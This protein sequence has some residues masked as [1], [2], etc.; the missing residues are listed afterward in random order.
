LSL[1]DN[2]P[3]FRLSRVHWYNGQALLP[4]HFNAQEESL[5]G[6]V[7]VRLNLAPVP[8]WGLGAL[9]FNKDWTTSGIISIERMVLV[10]R[11]GVVLD[12]PGNT[13]P[14]SF[15]LPDA[16]KV[17]LY[18]HL[19]G[20]SRIETQKGSPDE[21]GI[22]RV[23]HKI[24]LSSEEI[25]PSD[26]PGPAFKI[27]E[28]G[29]DPEGN[30][31]VN[32][33]YLPPLICVGRSKPLFDLQLGRMSNAARDLREVLLEDV[34][35]QYLDGESLAAAKVALRAVFTF[36]HLLDDIDNGIAPHPYEVFRALR[37]LLVDIYG[38]RNVPMTFRDKSYN[39]KKL[40][41]CLEFYLK[42][43]EEQS[44]IRTKAVPYLPFLKNEDLLECPIGP[45]IKR[46]S[47][48]YLLVKKPEVTTKVDLDGIKLGSP[49]RIKMIHERALP[50]IKHERI[51]NP[52]FHH[53]L[54]ANVEFYRLTAGQ[55]WDNAVSAG[56]IVLY[57]N[58]KLL[59]GS[60]LYLHF[61]GE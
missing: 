49:L 58:K 57:D 8:L 45:E 27:A 53:G 23:V 28:V 13:D 5:R 3:A 30:F 39:H 59:Q 31:S 50:G 52:P 41:E 14:V 47:L 48:V 18:V 25:P 42:E 7:D 17:P 9:S 21:E 40:A 12:I 2:N 19:I 38:Y 11:S 33:D 61:R 24:A 29:S 56:R 54:S 55:E 6:E 4:E 10:L 37:E 36:E 46:A 43:L 34:A 15:K 1:D 26:S 22:Q 44:Q 32:A 20:A 51:Q 35:R 16:A 60:R